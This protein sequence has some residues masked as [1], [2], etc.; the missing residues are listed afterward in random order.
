VN[1]FIHKGHFDDHIG[2]AFFFD[3]K[4]EA[5]QQIT[6]HVLD[7]ERCRNCAFRVFEE[8]HYPPLTEPIATEPKTD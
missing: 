8:C 7:H 6:E 5:I 2:S 3:T 1:T 4:R